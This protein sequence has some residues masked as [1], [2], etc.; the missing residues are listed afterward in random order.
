MNIRTLLVSLWLVATLGTGCVTPSTVIPVTLKSTRP[1]AHV[2]EK[3]RGTHCD[4]CDCASTST[5]HME[6]AH[7]Y[8]YNMA[9]GTPLAY[10]IE[11]RTN[12]ATACHSC[13]LRIL[14]HGN[15]SKYWDTRAAEL[16]EEFKYNR[17]HHLPPP[18]QADIDSG[19]AL[20]TR[21]RFAA[22]REH[23]DND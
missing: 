8:P 18:S 5:N 23:D 2:Y 7:F 22:K 4:L 9:V 14:H 12:G 6:W 11:A 13:H 19:R 20:Y 16:V 15:F 3:F 1:E 21:S 17:E 10:L